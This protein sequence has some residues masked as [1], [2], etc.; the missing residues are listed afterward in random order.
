[1]DEFNNYFVGANLAREIKQ[2]S[3]RSSFNDDMCRHAESMFL[4]R[5]NEKEVI[6]IINEFKNKTS[7]DYNDIV[8]VHVYYVHVY[9]EISS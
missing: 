7:T 3:D 6:D 4:N 2:T 5:V 8:Y 1:M 9:R